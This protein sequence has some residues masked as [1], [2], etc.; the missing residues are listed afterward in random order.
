VSLIPLLVRQRGAATLTFVVATLA[1]MLA[2]S[3]SSAVASDARLGV[4][5][6]TWSKTIAADARSVSLNARQ[7]HPRLMTASAARFSRDSLRA[8]AAIALQRPSSSKGR[9]AKGLALRAFGDYTLAGRRW[10]ASGR[11]RLRGH[12][13]DATTLA[14]T[15]ATYATNGNRLLVAAGALLS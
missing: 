9:R 8:R 2:G 3:A 10:A 14:R 6:H 12:R 11:A 4:V 15:G 5:V 13:R 1:L 7:R